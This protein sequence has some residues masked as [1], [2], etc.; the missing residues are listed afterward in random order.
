MPRNR[1]VVRRSA[2]L[3]QDQIEVH[4]RSAGER[5]EP[6]DTD[7]GRS[8]K[9]D[10]GSTAWIEQCAVVDGSSEGRVVPEHTVD[11]ENVGDQVVGECSQLV[12]IVEEPL[13][14]LAT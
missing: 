1:L 6:F 10:L 14:E 2:S 12:E 3:P 4:R 11:T 7:D 8:A 5:D 13:L 9:L